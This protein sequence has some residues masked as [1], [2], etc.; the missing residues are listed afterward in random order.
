MLLHA[1]MPAILHATLLRYA[2]L[3]SPLPDDYAAMRQRDVIR[4]QARHCRHAEAMFSLSCQDITLIY[5][6]PILHTL[7]RYV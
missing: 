4:C 5:A 6:M 1:D 3:I 2:L 7:P